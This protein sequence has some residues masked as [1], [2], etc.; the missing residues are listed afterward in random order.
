MP[1]LRRT[2]TPSIDVTTSILTDAA[3]TYLTRVAPF[4]VS[5]LDY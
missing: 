1:A 5:V 4:S 3:R 2:A